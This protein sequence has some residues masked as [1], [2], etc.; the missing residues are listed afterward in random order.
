G[1]LLAVVVAKPCF[2]VGA[3]RSELEHREDTAASTDSLASVEHRCPARGQDRQ[4]DQYDHRRKEH[5]QRGRERQIDGSQREVDAPAGRRLLR[6]P[7]VAL[8]EGL[9]MHGRA[10]STPSSVIMETYG[11]SSA[12]RLL[13]RRRTSQLL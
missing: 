4:G 1:Q 6:E 12:R 13:R 9:R 10:E 5:E 11:Y 3:Q 7:R 8:R 2:G